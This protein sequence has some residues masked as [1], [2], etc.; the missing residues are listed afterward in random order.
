MHKGFKINSL[1][2]MI[3][4]HTVAAPIDDHAKRSIGTA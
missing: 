2:K 4:F 1:N 3:K